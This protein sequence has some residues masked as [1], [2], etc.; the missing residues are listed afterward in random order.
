VPELE[1]FGPSMVETAWR[2]RDE[3]VLEEPLHYNFPLGFESSLS[4]A[5]RNLANLVAMLP[6]G[7]IWGLVHEGMVDLSLQAVALGLG[8]TVLRVGYEDGGYLRRGVPATSN[9]QLV[10]QLVAL[11]RAA[12]LDVATTAEAREIMK[13]PGKGS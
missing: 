13:L 11:I 2:L 1:I 9:A 8:A 12:G 4:A 5:P 7:S 10:E 3:G 6:E